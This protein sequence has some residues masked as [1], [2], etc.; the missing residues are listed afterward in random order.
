MPAVFFLLTTR[1]PWLDRRLG[2][3]R[4]KP[5]LW[6]AGNTGRASISLSVNFVGREPKGLSCRVFYWTCRVVVAT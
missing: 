4:R 3:G 5:L 2:E 6:T 1:G